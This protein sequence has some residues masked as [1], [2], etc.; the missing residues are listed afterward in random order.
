MHAMASGS[1]AQPVAQTQPC[2]LALPSRST[3]RSPVLAHGPVAGRADAPLPALAPL[4][5]AAAARPATGALGDV[6]APPVT[7]AW[8]AAALE[9]AGALGGAA[10]IQGEPLPLPAAADTAPLPA[11]ELA[12]CARELLL[13]AAGVVGAAQPVSQTKANNSRIGLLIAA[14][15]AAR[16]SCRPGSRKPTDR[17]A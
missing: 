4:P 5:A 2:V 1:S 3:M 14:P 9:E 7:W 10:T 15:A 8:A 16:G 6:P 17:T 13:V 12:G 11:V